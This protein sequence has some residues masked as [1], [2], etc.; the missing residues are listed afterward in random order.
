MLLYSEAPPGVLRPDFSA[1]FSSLKYRLNDSHRIKSAMVFQGVPTLRSYEPWSKLLVRLAWDPYGKP[2]RLHIRCSVTAGHM[3]VCMLGPPLCPS[4]E[5]RCIQ[6]RVHGH[7]CAP[8][9]E[10]LFEALISS[11]S[12]ALAF[13]PGLF[14]W[15]P[16]VQ[17]E[18]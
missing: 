13:E 6:D 16:W 7:P 17:P 9:Q 14:F 3:H 4:L 8:G 15:E 10:P 18:Q 1:P 2:A 11:D 12:F 5:G